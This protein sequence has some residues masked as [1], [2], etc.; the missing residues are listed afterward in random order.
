[1]LLSEQI[2]VYRELEGRLGTLSPP[3][4]MTTNYKMSSFIYLDNDFW[5]NSLDS[6]CTCNYLIVDS[7]MSQT[8]S[9]SKLNFR[10]VDS[11]IVLY[12]EGHNS[13]I[14]NE[15][16]VNEHLTESLFDKLSNR[17]GHTSI[18][19]R[20]GLQIVIIFCHCFC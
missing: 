9:P 10:Y 5:C 17:S 18:S 11:P 6:I 4:D 14:R 12:W 16:E 1:M 20:Q 8:A 2:V 7:N 19:H 3:S 15:I 13:S